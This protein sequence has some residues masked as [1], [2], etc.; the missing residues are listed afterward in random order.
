MLAGTIV[1]FSIRRRTPRMHDRR[2]R[3]GA[4]WPRRRGAHRLHAVARHR[5]APRVARPPTDEVLGLAAARKWSSCSTH[6]DRESATSSYFAKASSVSARSNIAFITPARGSAG[7]VPSAGGSACGLSSR[8][9]GTPTGVARYMRSGSDSHLPAFASPAQRA[10]T[11]SW[12]ERDDRGGTSPCTAPSCSWDSRCTRP[13]P[14][15]GPERRLVL[16][17]RPS[18][19][20]RVA[21]VAYA[22]GHSPHACLHDCD[23]KPGL[24]VHSPLSAGHLLRRAPSASTRGRD[25]RAAAA[26]PARPLLSRSAAAPPAPSGP[27]RAAR[28]PPAAL[29]AAVV[30]GLEVGVRGDEDEDRH[31]RQHDEEEGGEEGEEGAPSLTRAQFA[32]LRAILRVDAAPPPANSALVSAIC[33]LRSRGLARGRPRRLLPRR[34]RRSSATG[35]CLLAS[36]APKRTRL[37]PAPAVGA[38]PRPRPPPACSHCSQRGRRAGDRVG[39]AA[40]GGGGARAAGGDARLARIPLARARRRGVGAAGDRARRRRRGALGVGLVQINGVECRVDGERIRAR[41]PSRW[42]TR[43]SSAASR[44]R[45]RGA[46]RRA[47]TRCTSSP[48]G[49]SSRCRARRRAAAA[50]PRASASCCVEPRRGRRGRQVLAAD[51]P[52]RRGPLGRALPDAPPLRRDWRD[53]RG[54]L[55]RRDMYRLTPRTDM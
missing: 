37:A 31:E 25:A 21:P 15:T 47:P 3:L 23:M 30:R 18:P 54:L 44:R 33:D 8:T 12:H 29:Q 36:L 35:R 32:A 14:P 40:R 7:S 41:P 46:R 5:S 20:C 26:P 19:R 34:A 11:S 2:P 52:P 17:T 49:W 45:R 43:S 42:P 28:P 48:T 53:A 38:R 22:P 1:T 55:T 10:G 50:C 51:D 4:G 13:P 6:G 16:Y 27:S 9:S 24:A 39:R